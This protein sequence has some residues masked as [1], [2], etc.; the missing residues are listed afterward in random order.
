MKKEVGKTGYNIISFL[1]GNELRLIQM[2][3]D[4]FYLNNLNFM[5]LNFILLLE[6]S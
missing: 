2:L 5:E 4:Y 3:Y 6:F 1:A